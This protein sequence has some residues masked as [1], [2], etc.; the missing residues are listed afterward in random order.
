VDAFLDVLETTGADFTNSFRSLSRVPL[1]GDEDYER[2]RQL[3]LDYFLSQCATPAE[4]E[5]I[6]RSRTDPR[7]G[8]YCI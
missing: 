8:L 6:H 3:W 4:M 2:R 7:S 1:P 5:D